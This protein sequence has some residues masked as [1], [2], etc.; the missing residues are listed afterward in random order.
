MNTSSPT[1]YL[2]DTNAISEA[3]KSRTNSGYMKWLS[4]T[5]D[6]NMY[7]SCLTLGEIQKGIAI[8]KPEQTRRLPPNYLEGLHEAFAGRI[9]ALDEDQCLLWGKL[10]GAAV[11]TG[12]TP[13]AIDSLLAAQAI[14]YKLTLVTRNTKDFDQ[15]DDLAILSPWT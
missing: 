7:I 10:V 13:Q 12:K 8:A 2:L 11:K 14:H 1:R 4:S 5:A 15:F 6:E 9:L 3:A